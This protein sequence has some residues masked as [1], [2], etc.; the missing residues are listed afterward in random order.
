MIENEYIK[1]AFMQIDNDMAN[2]GSSDYYK[3]SFRNT[4]EAHVPYFR[5][6]QETYALQVNPNDLIVYNQDLFGF[7]LSRNI[8]P[9]FHWLIMRVNDMFSPY[10]FTGEIY[11]ILVPS[12][13]DLESIRQSWNA[14]T[15]ITS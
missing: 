5:K 10:S 6:A 4:L 8:K 12:T 1:K 2:D 14:T 3:E 7:L 15:T 13:K 11:Q 9:C